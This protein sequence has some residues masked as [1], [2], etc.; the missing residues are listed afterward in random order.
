MF[1]MNKRRFDN[2]TEVEKM[3]ETINK[4]AELSL[5]KQRENDP[6]RNKEIYESYLNN[7]NKDFSGEDIQEIQK[8]FFKKYIE[9]VDYYDQCNFQQY[10]K[11][12]EQLEKDLQEYERYKKVQRNRDEYFD[13]HEN[14]MPS[15]DFVL[16]QAKSKY[17]F[18]SYIDFDNP[19]V[20]ADMKTRKYQ[21]E[22]AGKQFSQNVQKTFAKTYTDIKETKIDGK[23]PDVIEVLKKNQQDKYDL[24]KEYYKKD[25]SLAYYDKI[26]TFAF[27]DV[28]CQVQLESYYR[29]YLKSDKIPEDEKNI[30]KESRLT[31]SKEQSYFLATFLTSVKKELDETEKE[32]KKKR[33]NI[34]NKEEKKKEE[35]KNQEH[36]KD[37]I[38]SNEYDNQISIDDLE[39]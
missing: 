32:L 29:K 35:N 24:N 34:Q 3:L 9:N 22:I 17:P 13:R 23:E 7:L 37:K 14:N 2:E 20:L 4:L 21:V 12:K 38:K 33:E 36:N 30:M 26:K 27:T 18:H 15:A 6:V 31:D 28:I 8:E 10:I 11:D 39:R 25:L 1:N 19:K 5:K 16:D